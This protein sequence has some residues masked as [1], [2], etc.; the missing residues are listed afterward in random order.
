[1]AVFRKDLVSI[2]SLALAHAKKLE[3]EIGEAVDDLVTKLLGND[4]LVIYYDENGSDTVQA[5]ENRTSLYDIFNYKW[6]KGDL[7]PKYSIFYLLINKYD[8]MQFFELTEIPSISEEQI[9]EFSNTK[10]INKKNYNYENLKDEEELNIVLNDVVNLETELFITI[11]RLAEKKP[12][13]L[14]KLFFEAL[15]EKGSL[16]ENPFKSLVGS[17]VDRRIYGDLANIILNKIDN[18]K[19]KEN[20]YLSLTQIIED[21]FCYYKSAVQVAAMGSD[22]IKKFKHTLLHSHENSFGSSI[23]YMCS[24]VYEGMPIYTK[25]GLDEF[26]K[27]PEDDNDYIFIFMRGGYSEFSPTGHYPEWIKK[28]FF[29]N[30]HLD[31][32]R[33]FFV[34]FEGDNEALIARRVA[35]RI[36]IGENENVGRKDIKVKGVAFNSAMGT[37][38]MELDYAL[39][40]WYAVSDSGKKIK[41]KMQIKKWLDEN[42]TLSNEAKNR[43]SI[44]ANWDKLGGATRTD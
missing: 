18:I 19:Y 31:A 21:D 32:H 20:E 1:M 10:S 8:A 33:L 9:A 39:Q 12:E 38:P 44:V 41:P 37:Y 29:K 2:P 22:D 14:E 6:W 4:A 28:Y 43:I 42:T 24:L 13:V 40:A 17:D 7:N 15:L 26:I 5:M 25:N 16:S 30:K 27:V 36:H 23:L 3:C 34:G 11:Q 35:F